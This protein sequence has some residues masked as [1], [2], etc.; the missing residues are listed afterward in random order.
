MN[1]A[2]VGYG[3]MGKEIEQIALSRGHKI[4][5]KVDK[6]NQD[7]LTDEDFKDIDVAIEFSIPEK[8]YTNINKCL[9]YNIPVVCG[10]TGWL[11]KKD[12]IIERCKTDNKTFFYASNYSLG[13]NLF[14]KLNE[15]LAKIMDQFSEYK[16]ALEETHHTQKLDAPS[17]T[18]ITLAQGIIDNNKSIKSWEQEC[19]T[20][21]DSLPIK[22][23]R[24][25]NVSGN[26]KIFYESEFDKITI[27]HDAKNRKG[28]ALGAVLAAEFIKGKT[29]YFTMNDLLKI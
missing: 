14:F 27:E 10:T 20:N 24:E 21:E 19:K 5:L 9:N 17:G 4:L 12:S 28:F 7:T 3:K 13:V 16:I 1:I 2:I 22:S 29:G 15:N 18:A 23:F 25:G 8:A 26:H 6:T 11:D